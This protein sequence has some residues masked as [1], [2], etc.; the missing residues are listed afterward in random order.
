MSP[1]EL[2][3]K[4]VSS[5]FIPEGMEGQAAK[6]FA[7]AFEEKGVDKV[8]SKILARMNRS[9]IRSMRILMAI[10][11][12]IPDVPAEERNPHPTEPKPPTIA[13]EI[14]AEKKDLKEAI[15]LNALIGSLYGKEPKPFTKPNHPRFD[16]H[17]SIFDATPYKDM[18]KDV[19][20]LYKAN[21]FMAVL[22]EAKNANT[23]M[24][25]ICRRKGLIYD[26]LLQ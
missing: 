5:G 8:E 17:P 18:P 25:E 7:Q 6:A 22:E 23:S 9:P 21:T 10:L 11:D 14:A 1:S 15:E 16:R 20:D 3:A 13:E 4:C 2:A 24:H 19:Q 26:L 12:E